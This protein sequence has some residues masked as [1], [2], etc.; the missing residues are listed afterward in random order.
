MQLTKEE[1]IDAA[2]N[3]TGG[4]LADLSLDQIQRLITISQYVTDLC[5]NELEGRDELELFMGSPMVP[6]CS[7]HGVET[8]LT[9]P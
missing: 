9:R 4:N 7:D 1:L 6:Y 5:L 8:I 2:Y 3:M